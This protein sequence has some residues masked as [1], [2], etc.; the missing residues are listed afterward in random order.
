MDNT[1]E[2][3]NGQS[4]AVYMKLVLSEIERLQE[5]IDKLEDRIREIKEKDLPHIET[6]LATLKTK[7]MIIGALSG[8]IF[9]AI[10]I[11]VAEL[12]IH[13]S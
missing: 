6:E 13:H 1:P 12:I 5:S 8:T 9:S 10:A 2:T 4:W 11:A 3:Q 7:A